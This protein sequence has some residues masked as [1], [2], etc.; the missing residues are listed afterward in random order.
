MDFRVA[1]LLG[2]LLQSCRHA[3]AIRLK[4]AIRGSLPEN[5][6][7][8]QD[9]A[10][11]AERD[12]VRFSPNYANS[13]AIRLKQAIRALRLKKNVPIRETPLGYQNS[14]KAAEHTDVRFIQHYAKSSTAAKCNSMLVTRAKE[15]CGG[16]GCGIIFV[17]DSLTEHLSGRPSC[18]RGLDQT[19]PL[20][21]NLSDFNLSMVI[22]DNWHPFVIAHGAH[23]TQHTIRDL[24][25][26]LPWLKTPKVFMVLIGSNNLLWGTSPKN[27]ARG[28]AAVVNRIRDV[29]PKV[30]VLL[31]GIWPRGGGVW[32]RGKPML[33]PRIDETND[34]LQSFGQSHQP[35]VEYI[36]CGHVF[37]KH[38]DMQDLFYDG[39]T[40]PNKLGY[41]KW[42]ACLK[43]LLEHAMSEST[44]YGNLTDRMNTSV[45]E[46]A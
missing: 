1:V 24:E 6:E 37:R 44:V 7:G 35:G 36:D 30:K 39:L 41:I 46:D 29:H 3:G 31:H 2:F 45:C 42:F 18:Y 25:R 15:N 11:A 28:V 20:P 5:P 9:P 43:P 12:D 13:W 40:H 14:A 22:P 4:Y 32:P 34:L 26:T 19:A 10:E 17:G 8:S 27:T 38:T 21:G 23:K 33:Q 16:H